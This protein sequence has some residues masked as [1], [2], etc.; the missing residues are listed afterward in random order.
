M[1]LLGVI[2]TA[3][4]GCTPGSWVTLELSP[5]QLLC[6]RHGYPLPAAAVVDNPFVTDDELAVRLVARYLARPT[7]DVDLGDP[8]VVGTRSVLRSV[9]RLLATLPDDAL[10]TVRG[11][12]LF[13]R[14]VDGRRGTRALHRLRWAAEADAESPSP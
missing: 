9:L 2:G 14:D 1:K 11:D 4:C 7:D 10:V 8:L 13:F 3:P 12:F 5:P 6:F